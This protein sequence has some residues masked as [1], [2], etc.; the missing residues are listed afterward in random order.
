MMPMIL[1]NG[2]T[3]PT[4]TLQIAQRSLSA[5]PA[6]VPISGTKSLSSSMIN[7]IHNAKPGCGSCGR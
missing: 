2:R 1:T 6:T 3:A 5:V 7:R 4:P